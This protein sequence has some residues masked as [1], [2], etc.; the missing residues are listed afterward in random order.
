[1]TSYKN[2]QSDNA[3]H[4]KNRS[5]HNPATNP[6]IK[7]KGKKEH[8]QLLDN[9]DSYVDFVSWGRWYP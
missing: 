7:A 4:S 5:N 3:K 8:G 6:A 1:M 2:F 9:I